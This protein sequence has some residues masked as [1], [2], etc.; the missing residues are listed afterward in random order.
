MYVCV[1]GR[2]SK[3]CVPMMKELFLMRQVCCVCVCLCVCVC[4]CVYVCVCACGRVCVCVMVCAYDE[5]ALPHASG[6]LCI[7]VYVYVC[8][9]V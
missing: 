1:W 3:S 9:Y 5:G 2:G 7:C 4:M 8:M 6:V